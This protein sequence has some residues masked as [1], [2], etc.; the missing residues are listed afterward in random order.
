M[1]KQNATPTKRCDRIDRHD[2]PNGHEWYEDKVFRR[3]CPGRSTTKSRSRNVRRRKGDR[4][5]TATD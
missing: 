3:W 5:G 4:H 2:W 1:S